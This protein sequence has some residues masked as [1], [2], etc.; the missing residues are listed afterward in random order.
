MCSS[1]LVDWVPTDPTVF[2]LARDKSEKPFGMAFVRLM[3]GDGTTLRD[4]RH[5]LIV[6]KV[7][8]AHQSITVTRVVKGGYTTGNV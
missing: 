2:P 6:Y 4:G 8:P 7:G 3:K 5:D 1:E